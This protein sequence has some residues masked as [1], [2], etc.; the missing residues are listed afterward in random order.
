[1]RFMC[2]EPHFSY[3]PPLH[4]ASSKMRP[5]TLVLLASWLLL[6]HEITCETFVSPRKLLGTK[7]SK[8]ANDSFIDYL[9]DVRSSERPYWTAVAE[10]NRTT[11]NDEE[12]NSY[13]SKLRTYQFSR[14]SDFNVSTAKSLSLFL[15][16]FADAQIGVTETKV[17]SAL[18]LSHCWVI[19]DICVPATTNYMLV[20][21]LEYIQFD[22]L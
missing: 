14:L 21:F 5:V 3:K 9:T 20:L 10:K 7:S 17:S 18:I 2:C 15:H 13:W 6:L 12:L 22:F 8:L 4:S 11:S 16:E 1:M 19:T